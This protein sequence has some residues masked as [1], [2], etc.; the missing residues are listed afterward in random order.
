MALSERRA[1]EALMGYVLNQFFRREVYIKG[2]TVRRADAT[3]RAFL[4]STAFKIIGRVGA[5]VGV[6][7]DVPVASMLAV[8]GVC[9][10]VGGSATFVSDSPA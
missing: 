10:A 8:P 9:V 7:A 3:T 4:E 6:V 2:K 5:L 1:L